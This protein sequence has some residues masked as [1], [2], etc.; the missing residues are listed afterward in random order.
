ML[1]GLAA[2]QG[3]VPYVAAGHEVDYVLG[4]V[5][6]VIADALQILGNHDQYRRSGE[7][8]GGIFRIMY[9]SNSRKS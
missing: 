2:V 9:V 4:Y 5:G 8:H 1:A 3:W 6:G 7:D